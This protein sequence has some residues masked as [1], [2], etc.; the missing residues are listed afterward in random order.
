M[1]AFL[2]GLSIGCAFAGFTLQSPAQNLLADGS[3]SST[4]ALTPY[5]YDFPF[6]QWCSW[7]GGVAS[8]STA[9]IDG[10]CKY[11]IVTPGSATWEIQLMQW[12][13]SVEKGAKYRLTFDVK[14]DV[15]RS[16]GVFIGEQYGSWTHFNWDIYQQ[17]ATTSWQ[18]KQLEFSVWNLYSLYKLSFEMG[19]QMGDIY[20]D[21][22]SLV[23]IGAADPIRIEMLGSAVPPY[24]WNSGVE[25]STTD[26][27]HYFLSNYTLPNGELK[28]RI[29]NNWGTNWGSIEFPAGVGYSGGPNIPVKSG[30]YDISFNR[31]TGEYKFYC[32]SCPPAISIIGSAVVP[33]YSWDR[34]RYMQTTDGITYSLNNCN[35]VWGELRFRQDGNWTNNWGGNSF[36]EGVGTIESP[37]IQVQPGNYKISFNRITGAYKFKLNIPVISLIGTGIAD[38]ETEVD[39]VSSDGINYILQNQKIKTGEVKF[40]QDHQWN[41]S[42][43]ASD[44]PWGY[45][46]NYG[47]NIPTQEGLYTIVF[48]RQ[49]GF[50]N[51]Q[52][53]CPTLDYEAPVLSEL[54][55]SQS[56]IWP[57]NHN[58]VEVEVNYEATDNC[59]VKDV[60]L[61]VISNEPV[62]GLNEG[63]KA[64]DWMIVDNHHVQLRAERAGNGKG[65]T[66]TITVTCTD[67]AGNVSKKSVNVF[68]PH[69]AADI[70][71]KG[72]EQVNATNAIAGALLASVT[73]NPSN[74]YFN[75]QINSSSAER[76]TVLILDATGRMLKAFPLNGNQT[77][78]FGNDLAPGI[79][80][81][82][83]K[84]GQLQKTIR[85]VKH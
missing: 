23:K 35:L 21:N 51:F 60:Q 41:I 48:N 43:G 54:K 69:D 71:M 77:M 27:I 83:L 79:Y 6:N 84:Q 56:I 61:S 13:F 73:P 18:T 1:K 68:V 64:P 46:Y 12:G 42:W 49:N 30:T 53:V 75:L 40:R 11:S 82:Q 24:N 8:F 10:V 34:D 17:Q 80:I 38:W 26:G 52:S 50:Y 15:N 22:I 9:V 29:L 14:A 25:L 3:F 47:S 33:Y 70:T 76:I 63:D 45:G 39:L 2:K 31:E 57:A 72:S 65:R 32:P 59:S 28:F 36:P 55:V 37:N 19:A 85:L 7:G 67:E 5:T 4:A 44:F 16:F 81:V 20:F 78:R 62:N 66:Y 58:M 74:G